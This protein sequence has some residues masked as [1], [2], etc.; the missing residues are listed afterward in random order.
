M[1]I[2]DGDPISTRYSTTVY[3]AGVIVRAFLGLRRQMG[4]T[5]RRREQQRLMNNRHPRMTITTRNAVMR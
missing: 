1:G 3:W 2:A 5:C 4:N